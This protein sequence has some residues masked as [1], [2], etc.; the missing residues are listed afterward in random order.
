MQSSIWRMRQ[1]IGGASRIHRTRWWLEKDPFAASSSL[2]SSLGQLE[3]L[4]GIE[5]LKDAI[6]DKLGV[7]GAAMT[8]LFGER[9]L[10]GINR[11]WDGDSLPIGSFVISGGAEAEDEGLARPFIQGES[12]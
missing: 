3:P 4:P 11:F 5:Q 1:W 10:N 12:H 6:R 2:A 7:S 8:K 9:H